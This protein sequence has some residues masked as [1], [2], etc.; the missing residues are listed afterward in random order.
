[1]GVYH[2]MGLGLSPGAVT[3]PLNALLTRLLLASK[4]DVNARRFFSGS[5]ERS[6]RDVAGKIEGLIFFTS[7]GVCN[8]ET[9]F[10]EYCSNEIGNMHGRQN[11]RKPARKEFM[12]IL[13]EIFSVNHL[14]KL[15]KNFNIGANSEQIEKIIPRNIPIFFVDIARGDF[16]TTF[17]RVFL[18]LHSLGMSGSLG[19]ET[20][21]NITSGDNPVN[22]SLITAGYITGNIRRMY[23]FQVENKYLKLINPWTSK[24]EDFLSCWKELP[25]YPVGIDRVEYWILKE[26]N[27]KKNKSI[28][29]EELTSYLKNL[30]PTIDPSLSTE[31]R[32]IKNRFI[33]PLRGQRLIEFKTNQ[34]NVIYLTPEGEKLFTSINRIY[35]LTYGNNDAIK[36]WQALQGIH[37]LYNNQD[38]FKWGQWIYKDTIE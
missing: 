25:V 37:A 18:V 30:I 8:N 31:S 9:K 28:K 20:W 34:N 22:A 35:E 32:Y 5:G 33:L 29:E 23:Y 16:D 3:M 14:E 1:M 17:E 2:A 19:K 7:K 10:F 15:N 4:G 11:D 13:S 24:I 6:G 21:A 38:V 27:S 26:I 36:N 12:K